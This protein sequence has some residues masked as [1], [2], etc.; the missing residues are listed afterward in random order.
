MFYPKLKI[1]D[2]F[3]NHKE[4]EEEEKEEEKRMPFL[5]GSSVTYFHLKNLE[6]ALIAEIK[7]SWVNL[8]K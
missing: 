5:T 6:N 3:I 7:A 1:K 4:E 2:Q 8:S